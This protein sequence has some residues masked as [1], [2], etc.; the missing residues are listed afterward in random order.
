MPHTRSARK[1]LRQ[2]EKRR[3]RNRAAIKAIKTQVKKVQSLIK[4]NAPFQD[5][6]KEVRLAIK[7]LDKAGQ[8]RILHPNNASRRKA[9]LA[10]WLS[11]YTRKATAGQGA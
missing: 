2:S 8:R 3:L 4:A 11:D 6:E 9:K 1:R 5:V 10:G 7:K